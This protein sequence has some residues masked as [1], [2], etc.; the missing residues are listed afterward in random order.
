MGGNKRK[1]IAVSVAALLAVGGAAAPGSATAKKKQG[2]AKKKGKRGARAGKARLVGFNSCGALRRYSRRHGG[3]GSKKRVGGGSGEV[4][5]LASPEADGQGAPATGLG[6]AGETPAFSQTN[7]QEPGI[8]EPDIAK[9]DGERI[10][11]LQGG[12]L[13]VIAA[14]PE[15]PLK[16]ASLEYRTGKGGRGISTP[17]DEL[18][19]FQARALIFSPLDSGRTLLTDVDL[20]APAAPRIVS[21]VNVEGGYVSARLNGATARAVFS[22][23]PQT[24]PVVPDA[25]TRV[26]ASARAKKRKLVQCRDVSH[27]A[28]FSGL[29]MLTVLTIDLARGLPA[30]DS[31]SITTAGDTV[32]GS[33]ESLY[34]ATE[35]YSGRAANATTAI[36]KFDLEPGATNYVGSGQ[37]EGY[38]L[39]QFSMSERNGLLR[40][41]STT[42]PTAAQRRSES[43]VTVLADSGGRLDPVGRVGNLGLGED[44]YA[45]RFI[46]DL[47]FVV[48][49]RRIDPLY[50]IGPRNPTAPAVL[51]ELKIQGY[52]AYLHPIA[53]GLLLG[54]G[55]DATTEGAALGT[56]LSLFDV[57]NPA[58]PAR[59][60]Q[61]VIS[62]SS[63]EV[64]E[65]HR[66]FL[67]W[68]PEQLA[69]VPL[70]V[71]DKQGHG[72]KFSGAA[73]FRAGPG[74]PDPGDRPLQ[75]RDRDP[76]PDP[77]HDGRRRPPLFGLRG[78]RA[79]EQPQDLAARGLDSLPVGAAWV[80]IRP[81]ES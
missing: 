9:T 47:A 81:A 24:R 58:A 38:M 43:F 15:G 67:Y 65:N 17:D 54:V 74:H 78:R 29:D 51:G 22:S 23:A 36:H 39:S 41:A 34:V 56:Q 72:L 12:K 31:D 6:S 5:P 8:D 3:A 26:P 28:R 33:V 53:P 52:S 49:F 63:S 80:A 10:Y 62:D 4:L 73:G 11:S 19:L 44:I 55:Q 21:T 20:S 1:L 45:V 66:A 50:V 79:G 40:V 37:V 71:T 7:V 18:L 57:S 46:E 30:I 60:S 13:H 64:E 25:V 75:P 14:N 35:T 16:L 59:L 42:D 70:E 27:P 32:Y 61:Q 48:T 77:A 76:V 68:P 69:V 2:A